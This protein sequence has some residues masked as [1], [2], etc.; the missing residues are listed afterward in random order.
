MTRIDIDDT[1]PGIILMSHGTMCEGIINSGKMIG[2]EGPNIVAL[3][4]M[5][6][7]DIEEYNSRAL[8]LLEKLPDGTIVL[9]DLFFGTPF[10]QMV[11]LCYEKN[12]KLHALCGMNLPIFIEAVN[13]RD[14]S[15]GDELI[16]ALRDVG[17]ESIIDV[18]AYM[19]EIKSKM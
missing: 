3:P 6:D 8:E 14:S 12:I 2:A 15:A 1:I 7:T 18:G 16:K 4:F 5:E 9:F 10:N 19:D 17:L 11:K 13:M